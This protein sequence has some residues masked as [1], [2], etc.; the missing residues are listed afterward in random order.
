[1]YYKYYWPCEKKKQENHFKC[2][3]L[4]SSNSCSTY[5]L[6]DQNIKSKHCPFLKSVYLWIS[7]VER[8][9]GNSSCHMIKLL[10]NFNVLFL[11]I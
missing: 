1:M 8:K 3:L 5:K 7:K 4:N 9:K 10:V 2:S 11:H 6:G